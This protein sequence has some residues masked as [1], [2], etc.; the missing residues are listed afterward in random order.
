MSV[1]G[2]CAICEAAEAEHQC[3]RCGAL[4]CSNHYDAET[5]LCTNCAAEVGPDHEPGYRT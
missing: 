5:G 4:V 3:D 1:S 2:L